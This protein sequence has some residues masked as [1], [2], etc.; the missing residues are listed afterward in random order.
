MLDTLE[1]VIPD[2]VAGLGLKPET[3]PQPRRL[4]LG[5]MPGLL[6][7][8]PF[9]VIRPAPAVF[10]VEGVAKG[11]N[12]FRQPGGAMLRLRPVSRSHPP[13]EDVRVR[14]AAALPVHHGRPGVAGV[15]RSGPSPAQEVYAVPLLV[16]GN[17]PQPPQPRHGPALLD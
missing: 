13:S 11:S 16:R 2:Q 14:A 7:S 15:A 3:G 8:G 10:G 9:R 17:A 1:Q 5:A 12:V 6:H 4:E